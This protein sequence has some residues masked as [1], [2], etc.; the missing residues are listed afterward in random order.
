[1]ARAEPDEATSSPGTRTR[2]TPSARAAASTSAASFSNGAAWRWQCESISRKRRGSHDR[3]GHV[4]VQAELVALCVVDH[5]VPA[6]ARD[7]C[8]WLDNLAAQA[9][10]LG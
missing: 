8:L 2:T 5:G 10:D 7:L 3:L 1:M 4:L 9:R 6:L